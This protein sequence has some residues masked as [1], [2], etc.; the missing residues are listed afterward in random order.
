M[1]KLIIVQT[2]VLFI[3]LLL[4][5]TVGCQQQPEPTPA[6]APV[7]TPAPAPVPSPAPTPPPP[8]T[9]TPP[10]APTLAPAEFE[11][12]SMN[13]KPMIAVAGE[14]VSITAVVKNIGGSEGT[15]AA[16]LTMDGVL[17]D[18]NEVAI[19]PG[20]SKVV[21]FSLVEE[22]SGTYEISI[23]DLT[24]TLTIGEELVL[25]EIELK[26]DDGEVKSF[27]SQSSRWGY[28]VHFSPPDT[29]FLIS[30]VEVLLRLYGT[31]PADQVA[32]L[33]IWDKDF[34]VLYS[35]EIPATELLPDPRW[36]T[37]ET[38][39][40][41]DSDFRVVFFTNW[42]EQEGGIS[43][44][45]DLSGN[46]ASE[47]A[48]ADGTYVGWI[49]QWESGPNAKP[50]DKINWMI[51]ATGTAMLPAVPKP[52]PKEVKLKYDSGQIEATTSQSPGWGY[53]VHFSPPAIPFT[54]SEV[55]IMAGLYSREYA[56]IVALLEIWDEDFD[57]L[58]SREI[59]ATE[60]SNVERWVTIETNITVNS[61]FRVVFFPNSGGDEGGIA[62][63]YD[64]SGNKASEVVKAGG[65]YVGWIPQW[66]SG[67]HPKPRETT[68]WMM[69][70]TGTYMLSAATVPEPS[71]EETEK[72]SKVEG[73][74]NPTYQELMDFLAL[75][76]T[77]ENTMSI[78]DYQ[79]DDFA[80]ELSNNADKAGFRSGFVKLRLANSH[81]W[82]LVVF[83]TTDKGMVAVEPLTDDV[84]PEPIV[85]ES[86][87][88]RD[89]KEA[90]EIIDLYIA[91]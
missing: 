2:M 43:I 53:S 65:T 62:I 86:F 47:V 14:T 22:I 40:T 44:G 72:V 21:T 6:P 38:N 69:R 73:L 87:K 30:Q 34:N 27:A 88:Q 77:N 66:E 49:P 32:S 9:S 1:K 18:A 83:Q 5:T 64:L 12:V 68:N 37:V 54:I 8:S 33:E 84:G 90:Y 23:G 81:A 51:R 57:V 7:P 3:L 70:V 24:S 11:I 10:P 25:K 41:V 80:A 13:I 16:M 55:K 45:Y 4:L 35:R 74:R 48:K 50:E 46:K 85:G 56:D 61:D 58:Y 31:V 19:T 75:D 20:G 60:L 28:S 52:S 63:G 67:S 89:W 39:I 79:I 36:V 15:Y 59:P 42:G 78:P 17:I 76:K 26:Y 71:P 82:F 29:P 91:W